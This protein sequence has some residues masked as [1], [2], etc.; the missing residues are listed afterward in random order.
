MKRSGILLLVFISFCSY[1]QVTINSLDDALQLMEQHSP[2][3]H[4][5]ALTD[6]SN[7]EK[8]SMAMSPLLP[9]VKAFAGFDNNVS[10]PVQLVPAKVLGG[11]EGEYARVQFGTRYSSNVGLEASLAL[12][13]LSNWKNVSAAKDARILSAHERRHKDLLATEKVVQQ[14]YLCLLAREAITMNTELVSASDSLLKAADVRYKNGSIELLDVNRVRS[15]YLETSQNYEE[16][17]AWFTKNVDALKVQLGTPL[18]DSLV[19]AESITA[20]ASGRPLALEISPTDLPS[21]ALSN[22]KAQ[23]MY[24]ES[25]RQQSKVLPEVSLYARYTRQS[26]SNEVSEL[27]N[28]PWFDVGVV[29]LRAEWYLFTGFNRQS[30]IRQSRYQKLIAD[31]EREGSRAEAERQLHELSIN[32]QLAFQ[33][34]SSARERYNL[35]LEN[36]RIAGVKYTEGVYAIDQYVTIYQDLIQAQNNYLRSLSDFLIY[37]GMVEARNRLTTSDK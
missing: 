5:S 16:S 11:P 21:Y 33:T 9:Q 2:A 26:F 23:Q 7:A 28:E 6:Q 35:N 29:G 22:A 27:T 24:Q 18:T 25:L 15:L 17:K 34:V 13:S 20:S 19:I 12:L 8:V 30:A 37:E 36:Y 1:S 31:T 3:F 14:Y 10:L 32:H 4:A